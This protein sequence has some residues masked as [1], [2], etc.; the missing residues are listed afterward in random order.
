[1][2]RRSLMA[3]LLGGAA[4]AAWPLAARCRPGWINSFALKKN[5]SQI[6]AGG[7]G[8]GLEVFGQPE[9]RG[10]PGERQKS[11]PPPQMQRNILPS[12][13]M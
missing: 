9:G 6:L 8:S 12:L 4:A 3:R 2:N 5:R 1:M 11:R 7:P 13:G 10:A